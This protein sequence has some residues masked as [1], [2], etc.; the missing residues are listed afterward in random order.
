MAFWLR[1]L[2]S[3]APRNPGRG[4]NS[5]MGS[6]GA[7]LPTYIF[8][9]TRVERRNGACERAFC[10]YF[11]FGF[12]FETCPTHTVNSGSGAT[13]QTPRRDARYLEQEGRASRF[14]GFALRAS[15]NTPSWYVPELF[16]SHLPTA[17]LSASPCVLTPAFTSCPHSHPPWVKKILLAFS[18]WQ[19]GSQESEKSV[20]TSSEAV[21]PLCGP[22]QATG[23]PDLPG[24]RL[25]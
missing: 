17:R 7:W 24:S 4:P 5:H 13:S 23:A 19:P 18:R 20:S 9:N 22:E 15:K 14:G 25:R 1:H 21:N 12:E 16:A 2:P 11:C 3:P 10:C 8:H 6:R